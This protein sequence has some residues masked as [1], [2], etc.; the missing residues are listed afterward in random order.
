MAS[1]PGVHTQWLFF[2]RTADLETSLAKVRAHGGLTLP[3]ARTPRGD[4]VAACD[5]PQGAAFG[6]YQFTS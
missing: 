4:L 3:A 2:F 6:L 1:L 5:D